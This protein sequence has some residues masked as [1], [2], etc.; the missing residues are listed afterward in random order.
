M[1]KEKDIMT[2]NLLILGAAQV[3]SAL[4]G[5]ESE[6]IEIVKDTYVFHNDGKTSL[7]HSIFLRFPN[8]DRNRIIGLPAYIGGDFN[9]AGMKWISSF[10]GN[11]EHNIERASAA[12]FLND[13]QTGRVN[14][15]LEGSII[16]AKRTAASAALAAKHLHTNKNEEAFGLIG[17]GRINKE[18]LLFVKNVFPTIKK[19]FMFDLSEDRMDNFISWHKDVDYEFVKCGSIEEVFQNAKLVSFATTA[20]VPF[21]DKIEAMTSEHTVLGISLRDLAPSVIEN[22]HNIVDDFE[23]VCRE[24]TS[25]HLTYQKLG[26]GDFVAGNIAEVVNGTVAAREEGKA[27]VYSPF[28]L[29]VLDLAVSNY[30]YQS[31]LKDNIGTVVEN[32]LP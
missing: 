27:S 8:D 13:M 29:G 6:I 22:A 24:R 23:H 2:N 19:I 9:I 3:N 12:I 21:I 20:G 14:A 15:V 31:A 26:N 25:I 10:P 1:K 4:E 32:F 17:C 30:I 28:G 18:I 5:K 7:P 16:S 11:I